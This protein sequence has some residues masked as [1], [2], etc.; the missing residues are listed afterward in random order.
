MSFELDEYTTQIHSAHFVEIE[1]SPVQVQSH[2]VHIEGIPLQSEGLPSSINGIPAPIEG[3]P[4]QSDGSQAQADEL[5]TQTEPSIPLQLEGLP[6]ILQVLS[7]VEHSQSDF[8]SDPMEIEEIP[9]EPH[10]QSDNDDP[11]RIRTK[12]DWLK[13]LQELSSKEDTTDSTN[14]R[15]NPSE[16]FWAGL[17][18]WFETRGYKLRPRYRPGWVASW[19][20]NPV[21]NLDPFDCEDWI[22]S[23]SVCISSIPRF[24]LLSV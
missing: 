22:V 19:L 24:I 14:S 12:E 10:I 3:L 21:D 15:L 2:L 7:Q 20:K 1:E 6:S 13:K 8:H 9:D 5:S 17:Q 4:I 18:P 11:N 16:Q 23:T